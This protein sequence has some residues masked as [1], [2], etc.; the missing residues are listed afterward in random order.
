MKW[1]YPEGYCQNRWFSWRGANGFY[2]DYERTVHSNTVLYQH[3]SIWGLV[4]WFI[5]KVKLDRTLISFFLL[6]TYS[7]GLISIF[8]CLQIWLPH[9]DLWFFGI[10]MIKVLQKQDWK[11]FQSLKPAHCLQKT[12]SKIWFDWKT[13]VRLL[14]DSWKKPKRLPKD[15]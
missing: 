15:S 13:S 6:D 10:F 7:S 2:T 12:D 8:S 1:N 9:S 4:E 11:D 5:Q 14:R 3:I